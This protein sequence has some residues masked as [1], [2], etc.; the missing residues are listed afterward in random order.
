MGTSAARAAADTRYFAR[1]DYIPGVKV[2]GMDVL[3]VREACQFAKNWMLSD[4]GPIVLEMVTYRYGGHS[5]SDPGTTYRTREEI[6]HMRSTRDPINGLKTRIIETD[7]ATED[8]LKQIDRKV[9]V[10]MDQAI[11]DSVAAPEPDMNE[12]YTDIYAKGT[13]IPFVR[14]V[15]QYD[16]QNFGK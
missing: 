12:L 2:N 6:Q 11:A 7:L 1:G 16:G 3:A 10:E 14:G 15:T 8:E 5:M 4:K 9:R 13:E